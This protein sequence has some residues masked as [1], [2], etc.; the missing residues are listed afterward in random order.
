MR[1]ASSLFL[2][3]TEHPERFVDSPL[4]RP[5]GSLGALIHDSYIA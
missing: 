3:S 2:E 4:E 1:P 5:Q